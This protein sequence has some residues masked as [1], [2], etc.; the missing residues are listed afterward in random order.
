MKRTITIDI[1]QKPPISGYGGYDLWKI[2]NI[3]DDEIDNF[4]DDLDE[5]VDNYCGKFEG[6]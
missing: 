3:S 2:Y 6:S 4:L 5:L 1:T